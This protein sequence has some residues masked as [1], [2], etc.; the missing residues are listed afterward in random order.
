[1]KGKLEE[2][3]SKFE[4]TCRSKLVRKRYTLNCMDLKASL[5]VEADLTR[6][7]EKET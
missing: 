1:M 2:E 5:A 4:Q 3:R 7:L 6:A